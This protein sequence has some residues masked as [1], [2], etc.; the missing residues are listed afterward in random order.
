MRKK[1]LL[2]AATLLF[3]ANAAFSQSR[4]STNLALIPFH[5]TG[6]GNICLDNL[7]VQSDGD[8][9]SSVKVYSHVP[10]GSNPGPAIWLGTVFYKLS[11]TSAEITDS[12]FA[13]PEMFPNL[14]YMLDRDP[15]GEGNVRINAEPDGEG[16]TNLHIAHFPDDDFIGNP[17]E[18]VVVPLCD[19]EILIFTNLYMI[20]CRG[21]IICKYHTN[22]TDTTYQAHIARYSLDGTLKYNAPLPDNQ[23]F[24]FN[25][26]VFSEQPLKY[27]QWD[28][29]DNL[30]FY[31]LDSLFQQENCYVINK[32]F[33]QGYDPLLV[34]FDFSN[35]LY[36]NQT[37]VITEGEDVLVAARYSDYS[38]GPSCPFYEF[39]ETGVAVARYNLRTMQQKALVMF[40]DYLGPESNV[41]PLGFFKSS[42]GAVFFVYRE[43]VWDEHGF[44]LPTP[45]TAVKMDSDLNVLWKRY[46]DL[47]KDHELSSVDGSVMEKDGDDR[48]KITVACHCTQIDKST[49]PYLYK[50]GLLYFFLA[51]DGTVGTNE[52]G[53]EVRPYAFYPNPV[54]QQL[55]ME[56]SPDVQPAKVE[57]YD[58]QGCLVRTLSK[59][60]ESIDMSQLPTGTYTMRVILE[61]GKVYSDKVVKE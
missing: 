19:E 28:G 16:G 57:L 58:L 43:S 60:F 53:I 35:N 41:Q 32:G 1:T 50:E 2:I 37:F 54:K 61:D 52:I 13:A 25:V 59:A 22:L 5:Y 8:L 47:P 4:D 10:S 23:L 51:D 29:S 7:M 55:R 17:S 21:D 24:N 48:I 40:N 34:H 33:L 12:L 39:L 14:C 15:Y 36:W 49:M 27:Y 30:S 11:P 45:I 9:V 18:D 42:E 44:E 31:V 6:Y 20:D 56:F 38:N 46:V 3:T 26:G